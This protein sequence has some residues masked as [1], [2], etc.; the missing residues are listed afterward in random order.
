MV[1]LASEAGIRGL[2]GVGYESLK[3]PFMTMP[4]CQ[5]VS[6]YSFLLVCLDIHTFCIAMI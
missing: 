3:S 5:S 6:I 2:D 1:P 4:N